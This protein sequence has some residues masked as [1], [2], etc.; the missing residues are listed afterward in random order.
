MGSCGSPGAWVTRVKAASRGRAAYRVMEGSGMSADFSQYSC[1]GLITV[2][3]FNSI[4][5]N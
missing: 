4:T 5:L 3:A 1:L 2:L